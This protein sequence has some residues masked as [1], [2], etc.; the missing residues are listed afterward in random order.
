[1]RILRHP[2]IIDVYDVGEAQGE[3]YM[4]MLLVEGETLVKRLTH[5]RLS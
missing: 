3:I 4:A 2:H 1:M 5:S